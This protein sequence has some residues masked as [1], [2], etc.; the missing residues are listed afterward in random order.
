[1]I[2][3]PAQLHLSAHEQWILAC[4]FLC[5]VQRPPHLLWIVDPLRKTVEAAGLT[6][7]S[8]L[9]QA[10]CDQEPLNGYRLRDCHKWNRQDICSADIVVG[11]HHCHLQFSFYS[12]CGKWKLDETTFRNDS[13]DNKSSEW[14]AYPLRSLNHCNLPHGL[15][16]DCDVFFMIEREVRRQTHLF[17]VYITK[18]NSLEQQ[19]NRTT[20]QRIRTNQKE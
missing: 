7:G 5:P 12:C 14:K 15:F 10:I 8:A 16:I 3:R 13:L 11:L 17:V 4:L 1:M 2:S 18:N 19:Q 9:P 6:V 20:T